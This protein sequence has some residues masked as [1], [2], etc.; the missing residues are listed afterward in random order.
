MWE[1]LVT[2]WHKGLKFEH[3]M[4]TDAMAA[5]A[6]RRQSCR[7]LFEPKSR[8]VVNMVTY[9]IYICKKQQNNK[10]LKNN[11]FQAL[12]W[13]RRIGA[14][15]T[16][17]TKRRPASAGTLGERGCGGPSAHS[18]FRCC[19]LSSDVGWHIRDK[20]RPMREHGSVLLYVHG[21]HKAR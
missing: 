11:Y 9:I 19:L 17:H 6:T 3:T 13:V 5:A 20:L 1:A 14:Q 8:H 18:Y 12:P 21:N 7:N 2:L 4:Y 16:V 10:P 15:V